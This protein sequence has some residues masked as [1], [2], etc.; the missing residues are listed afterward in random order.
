MQQ[1]FFTADLHLGHEA[2]I[3]LSHRPFAT[4]E[5]MDS[6]IID[7]IN[8]RVASGDLL[9]VLGDFTIHG[10]EKAKEYRKRIKCQNM[11]LIEGNHDRLNAAKCRDLFTWCLP[12][13]EVKKSDQHITLCH[14]AMRRWNKSHHG[15]WQLYGHSH[16][17]LEDDAKLLSFDV[18]VDCHDF[19][20]LS[21][22][23]VCGIM[24]KRVE[25]GAVGAPNH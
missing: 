21:F 7:R 17:C 12:L 3:R 13:A 18:G 22:S 19:Y 15:A 2:I 24:A 25:N 1:S 20:P 16:G 9:Y 5:E 23:D 8:L 14:Y 4:V 10:Y 6:T 11:Y